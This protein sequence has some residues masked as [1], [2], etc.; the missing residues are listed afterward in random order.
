MIKLRQ[1]LF[2]S[3]HFVYAKY[4]GK[5]YSLHYH[6]E[7]SYPFLMYRDEVFVGEKNEIHGDILNT[8][9]DYDVYQDEDYYDRIRGY[10]FAGRLW[11]LDKIIS[12]W[13]MPKSKTDWNFCLKEIEIGMKKR[14]NVKIN[15]KDGKWLLNNKYKKGNDTKPQTLVPL[16][17]VF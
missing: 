5:Q 1:I 13:D 3:P 15:F 11:L 8:G 9:I 10:K 6:D 4:K 2:E 16:L 7:G 12:F 14:N 17:K